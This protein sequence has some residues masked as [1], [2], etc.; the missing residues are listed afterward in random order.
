MTNYY[1]G[2]NATSINS[3]NIDQNTAPT[4]NQILK[5]N[6]TTNTIE[7]GA[8]S[9]STDATELQGVSIDSTA[10][11]D[12]D[13]LIYQSSTSK[14]TPTA[15]AGGGGKIVQVVSGVHE[16]YYYMSNNWQSTG[17]YVS[18][19]P[20]DSANKIVGT[21]SLA[22]AGANAVDT[23]YNMQ[24]YR[25][26]SIISA[27]SSASG[28]DWIFSN[29][30]WP[31]GVSVTEELDGNNQLSQ[32]FLCLNFTDDAYATTSTIYYNIFQRH[33]NNSY[34]AHIVESPWHWFLFE[35]DES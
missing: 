34:P 30:V 8:D 24:L 3:I 26:T 20:T 19:T 35:I 21:M 1:G 31:G 15:S 7:W 17:E 6:S 10:P 9:T 4:S 18:I 28:G 11:T 32:N 12:Q 27:G 25:S 13:H 5:Y 16:F 29:S 14:W 23:D 33:W 2:R 22:T